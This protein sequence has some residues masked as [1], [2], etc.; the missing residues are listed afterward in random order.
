MYWDIE[1]L[2]AQQAHPSCRWYKYGKRQR[3]IWLG[4]TAFAGLGLLFLAMIIGFIFYGLH[5]GDSDARSGTS[6]KGFQVAQYLPDA[7]TEHPRMAIL[8]APCSLP[9]SA[10][11]G[12]RVCALVIAV[13]R[14]GKM[15]L[16]AYL[17]GQGLRLANHRQLMLCG[18]PSCRGNGRM[19]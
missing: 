14:T 9:L 5:S 10:E 12:F 17:G 11:H 15:K 8:P 2:H 13:W 19:R 4:Y 3:R 16:P 1:C 7:S 6:A 18:F